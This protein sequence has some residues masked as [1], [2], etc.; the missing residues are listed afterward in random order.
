MKR[1]KGAKEMFHIP[2]SDMVYY[3]E[4]SPSG[5]RHARDVTYGNGNTLYRAR[6]GAVAGSIAK[7][8]YYVYGSSQ[9]GVFQVH[10]IIWILCNGSDIPHDSLVDHVD[11]NK[12]NNKL[13]NLRLLKE[14][15]NTRNAKLYSNNTSGIV[16]VYF[17]TKTFGNKL[18]RDYW[19]ASW[20]E[21]DG[22]QKTKAFSIEKFGM[23]PAMKMACEYRLEQI[24]KLNN[25]GAGYTDRHGT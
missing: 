2:W 7:S 16:G 24:K 11:G 9:Y 15:S 4:T 18:P 12:Q 14:A 1:V 3:D 6:K 8:N 20:M 19:K 5:L 23:L 22:V 17:D 13:S 21:L 10:R 25:E